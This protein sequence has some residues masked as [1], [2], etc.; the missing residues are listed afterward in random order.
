MEHLKCHTSVKTYQEA[1]ICTSSLFWHVEGMCKYEMVV[2]CGRTW[3]FAGV[4]TSLNY[5]IDAPIFV[6]Y[7]MVHRSGLL[8]ITATS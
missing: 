7:A 3:L 1:V 4:F 6:L 2:S 8:A 5:C